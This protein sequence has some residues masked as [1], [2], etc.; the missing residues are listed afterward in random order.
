MLQACQGHRVTVELRNESFA[1][2]IVAQVDGYM[3]VNMFN[4]EFTK[5]GSETVALEELFIQGRQIRFVQIPDEINM[6]EAIELQLKSLRSAG[7]PRIRKKGRKF[8]R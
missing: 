5:N 8:D 7:A 4:V 6:R 3:N 2:G 1:E